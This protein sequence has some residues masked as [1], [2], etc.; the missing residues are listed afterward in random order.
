MSR[1]MKSYV[2][3]REFNL[4]V[5]LR[6]EFPE[7]YEGELDGYE[8]A[9]EVPT[10][11]GQLVR[12]AAAALGNRPGWKLMGGNRGKPSEEEVTI[13]LTKLLPDERPTPP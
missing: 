10:V 8:W 1:E 7:D 4:R 2:E 6:C 9:A 11:V 12:S 13:V 3:E 5:V